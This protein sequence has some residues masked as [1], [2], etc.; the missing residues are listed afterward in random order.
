M[1]LFPVSVLT[2]LFAISFAHAH[3]TT[4]GGIPLDT[5]WKQSLYQFAQIRGNAW[6]SRNT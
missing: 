3:E 4:E 6:I 1:K 2:T 5:E